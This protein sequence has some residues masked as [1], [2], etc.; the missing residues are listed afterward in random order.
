M[1]DSF[2]TQCGARFLEAAR[3]CTGC[4]HPRSGGAPNPA[5]QP[6]PV[7]GVA[8][9][10]YAPVVVIGGVL[11]MVAA[12]VIVG[13]LSPREP[14]NIVPRQGAGAGSPPAAAGGVPQDHPP[15]TIPPQVKQAIADLEKKAT[16]NP[17]DPSAWTHLGEVLYRAG[18]IEPAYLEGAEKA[19]TRLL[20]LDPK[21]L[22]TLRSLGN[23]SFDR[24]QPAVAIGHYQKY[25][26]IKPDDL[27]VQTD[28]ATMFLANGE[29]ERAVRA[30]DAVL[31]VDPN[32]FQA[33][34]NLALAYRA[35]GQAEAAHA[36]LEKARDN[37][38][39]E[40]TKK[41]LTQLL[42]RG[43][44]APGEV[45][46]PAA[47]PPPAQG[48]EAPTFQTAVESI[49]RTHQIIASKVQ[50]LEWESPTSAKLVLTGF[51]MEQMPP[52]M[53]TMFTTRM[54][55]RLRAA[56]QTHGITDTV[57]IALVDFESGKLMDT[58]SE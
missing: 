44:P 30:Y 56:K 33:H 22:D 5:V 11:L 9:A 49:F 17:Q 10:R 36:S 21:N 34:F 29:T 32:F 55:D 19:F 14:V 23:I 7:S 39:D 37:A 42:E 46:A 54:Q 47:P 2:C 52:E 20:E 12:A 51:P 6:S 40:E 16:D 31:K 8:L 18:Q 38:P 25:L 35:A 48:G 53:R 26:E 45:A 57:K 3:F 4:G 15:L 1:A 58:L 43:L 13:V 28:M 41:Q 50:S 27:A 24:N